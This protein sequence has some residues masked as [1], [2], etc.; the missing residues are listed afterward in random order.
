MSSVANNQYHELAQQIIAE[1][2]ASRT[3]GQEQDNEDNRASEAPEGMTYQEALEIVTQEVLNNGAEVIADFLPA[4]LDMS[5]PQAVQEA[6]LSIPEEEIIEL[7]MLIV[8]NAPVESEGD[9]VPSG[10]TA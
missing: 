1:D 2:T 8:G 10:L 4:D 5:N 6:V 9:Q 7:A 3:N